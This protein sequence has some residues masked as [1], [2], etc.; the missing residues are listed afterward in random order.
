MTMTP[1]TMDDFNGY[2]APYVGDK[3][4]LALLLDYD[5]TL[6]PIAKHPDLAILPPETKKVLERLANRPDVFISIISGRSVESVVHPRRVAFVS[7]AWCAVPTEG[8]PIATRTAAPRRPASIPAC[9]VLSWK[10]QRIPGTWPGAGLARRG[11]PGN[12]WSPVTEATGLTIGL[13]DAQ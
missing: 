3:A 5:G 7:A 2:L 13:G 9:S 1:V 6:S 10:G 11:H 4:I 8:N 12:V